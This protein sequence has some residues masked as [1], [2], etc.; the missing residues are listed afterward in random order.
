MKRQIAFY[1]STRTYLPVLEVHGF[2]E[3]GQKLHELSLKGEWNQMARL[4]NDEMLETF[5]VIGPHD[6][7]AGRLKERFGGLID[8][9]SINT[10][11]EVRM[12]ESAMPKIIEQLHN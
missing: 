2:Q 12:D 7:V 10:G 6:E 1:F 4:I 8:E 5:A 9:L 3:V 11:P